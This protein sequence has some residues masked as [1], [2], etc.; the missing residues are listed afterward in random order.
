MIT[1]IGWVADF[2]WQIHSILD[3]IMSNFNYTIHNSRL[4][5]QMQVILSL[6]FSSHTSKMHNEYDNA[7]LCRR[8]C[9][10][11]YKCAI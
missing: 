7:Q 4:V 9:H 10:H 3:K 6:Y 8:Y 2:N 1:C 5:Q 11:Y